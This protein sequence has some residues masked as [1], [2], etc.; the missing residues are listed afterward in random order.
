[1]LSM[2]VPGLGTPK[3]AGLCSHF[4]HIWAPETAVAMEPLLISSLRLVLGTLKAAGGYVATLP[5]MLR[6]HG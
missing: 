4:A 3:K 6:R 1:M 2:F 5:A